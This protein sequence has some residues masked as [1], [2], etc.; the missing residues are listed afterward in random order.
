MHD[1]CLK[2]GFPFFSNMFLVHNDLKVWA[3]YQQHFLVAHNF[4]LYI[5][6]QKS[7]KHLKPNMVKMDFYPPTLKA[8]MSQSFLY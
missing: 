7:H 2:T 6:T 4:P 8:Y 1:E 3:L 5:S